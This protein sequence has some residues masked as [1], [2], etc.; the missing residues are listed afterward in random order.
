M[1]RQYDGKWYWFETDSEYI[2]D[3]LR[4]LLAQNNIYY[5]LSGSEYESFWHFEMCL[6]L[7]YERNVIDDWIEENTI[8][9][10]NARKE[11]CYGND[12]LQNE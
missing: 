1:Y 3:G 11:N 9:E 10:E 2:K 12:K 5:E 7:D 8:A 4:E 6:S